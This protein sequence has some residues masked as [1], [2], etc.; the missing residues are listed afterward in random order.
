MTARW[1]RH[2]ERNCVELFYTSRTADINHS[3]FGSTT[4]GR[5]VRCNRPRVVGDSGANI[6]I[7]NVTLWQDALLVS[8]DD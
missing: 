6:K 3:R 8:E 7:S 1:H 5:H 2:G 4:G